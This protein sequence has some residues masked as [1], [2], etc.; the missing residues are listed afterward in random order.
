M[1]DTATAADTLQ[2]RRAAAVALAAEI[3][4]KLD[5][6]PTQLLRER[7]HRVVRLINRPDALIARRNRR[8]R[9]VCFEEGEDGNA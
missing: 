6:H 4:A 9:P 3:E 8:P 7:L 5:L 2:V 1:T